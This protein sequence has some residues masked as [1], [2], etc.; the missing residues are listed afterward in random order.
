MSYQKQHEQAHLFGGAL[1]SVLGLNGFEICDTKFSYGCYHEFIGRA[2]VDQ[3]T[4]VIPKLNKGCIALRGGKLAC[5]HGI[6][7]GI[8]GYI[9]Y[10]PQ[11]LSEAVKLCNLLPDSDPIG[12]C[13]G[14]L[15]ME[16]N[17]RTMWG[18]DART[19]EYNPT[20]PFEPCDSFS[21]AD[22]RRACIYW[23]VQ[24]WDQVVAPR[25][26]T[27]TAFKRMGDLCRESKRLYGVYEECFQ[28]IG[29]ITAFDATF[30]PLKAVELCSEAG[31][32]AQ[33]RF[34]CIA[35]AVNHIGG[36]VSAKE[37]QRACPHVAPQFR[38]ECLRWSTN[39]FNIIMHD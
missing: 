35:L 20:K 13:Y 16:Y 7:H 19:R 33:E 11:D 25:D 22:E 14:G 24:W 23:Q 38:A 9:G 17:L 15:F 6:G 39:D 21:R 1:Y 30:D 27:K 26:E 10:A 5:Q 29:N 34:W 37:A 8:V 4:D 36:T 28:G 18:A 32:T 12:G 3:D 2:I 31:V